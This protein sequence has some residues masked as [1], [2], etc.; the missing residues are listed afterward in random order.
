[1]ATVLE[2]LGA[3]VPARWD[4]ASFAAGLSSGTVSGRDHLVL[5]HAGWTAQRSVRFGPR[6]CVRTYHGAFHGLPDLILFDLTADPFEQHSVAADHPEVVDHAPSLLHES[7]GGRPAALADRGRPPVEG[8]QRRRP[9]AL[10]GG[11]RVVSRSAEEDRASSA[12]PRMAAATD[13]QVGWRVISSCTLSWRI[14]RRSDGS[15]P[16][17]SRTYSIGSGRASMWGQSEPKMTRS[18]PTHS[19]TS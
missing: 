7:G 18:A 13:R 12:D 19:A 17:S 14:R 16:L 8:A 15:N 4:G 2:L 11:C 3:E 5:S 6:I 1:M 9:L 10:P